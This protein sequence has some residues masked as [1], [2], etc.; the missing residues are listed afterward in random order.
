MENKL[1]E[2]HLNHGISLMMLLLSLRRDMK[3][4]GYSTIRCIVMDESERDE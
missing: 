1:G 3:G 4:D 2:A